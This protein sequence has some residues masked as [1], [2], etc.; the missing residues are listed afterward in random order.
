MN[1]NYTALL[2]MVKTKG[3]MWCDFETKEAVGGKCVNFK[4]K[5]SC[6]GLC[7][8]FIIRGKSR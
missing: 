3:E 4:T 8:D 2:K 7:T 1:L 5:G 6:G